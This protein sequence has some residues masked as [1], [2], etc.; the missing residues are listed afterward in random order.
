MAIWPLEY[1][2]VCERVGNWASVGGGGGG[3][4][5]TFFYTP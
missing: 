2:Q 3:A 5:A 4:V 1:N